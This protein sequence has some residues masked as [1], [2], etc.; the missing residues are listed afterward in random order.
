MWKSNADRHEAAQHERQV[1][2]AARVMLPMMDVARLVEHT[3]EAVRRRVAHHERLAQ[4]MAA[5]EASAGERSPGVIR[6]LAAWAEEH[7]AG[8]FRQHESSEAVGR[9]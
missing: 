9:R 8:V 4:A 7:V 1:R 3:P 2:S 6:R 5:H